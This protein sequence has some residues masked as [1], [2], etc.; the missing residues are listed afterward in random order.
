MEMNN[1]EKSVTKTELIEEQIEKEVKREKCFVIMPIGELDGIYP[2]DH[3]RHVYEDIFKPA[4]EKAGYEAHRVDYN[5]SSSLI[6][7][8]IVKKIVESSM[9]LCDLSTRNP[10]VLFELGIRQA[11]DKPVVLVQET[12]TQRIF[13]VSTINTIEYRKERIFH[14]VIEDREKVYEAIIETQKDSSN[15]SIIKMLQISQASLNDSPKMDDNQE[16]KLMLKTLMRDITDLKSNGYQNSSLRDK[17]YSINDMDNL[18]FDDVNEI[19]NFV[20]RLNKLSFENLAESKKYNFAL[21]CEKYLNSLQYAN[22]I[23]DSTNAKFTLILEDYLKK[24]R[25]R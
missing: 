5:K 8:E 15:N 17:L 11:Y 10:N 21:K 9:V 2:K 1:G 18:S 19:M 13:D 22:N 6:Q 14:E 25:N 23:E 24:Y 20:N 4:I 3:F 7:V 12:G 16:M